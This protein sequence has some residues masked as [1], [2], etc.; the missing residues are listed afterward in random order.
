MAGYF[1]FGYIAWIYFMVFSLHGAGAEGGSE[2]RRRFRFCPCTRGA[3]SDRM[4]RR[5]GLRVA[6]ADWQRVAGGD[7]SIL[8]ASDRRC[9]M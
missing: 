1:S 9:A 6:G 3:M 7:G 4:T 8:G 2:L 5:W